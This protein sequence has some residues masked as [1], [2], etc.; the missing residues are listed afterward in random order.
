[1]EAKAEMERAIVDG[2]L[3]KLK[4]L[5]DSG[6]DINERLSYNSFSAVHLAVRHY[7]TDI[8]RFL[9]EEKK[10]NPDSEDEAGFSPLF[11]LCSDTSNDEDEKIVLECFNLL[12]SANADLDIESKNSWTMSAIE[13]AV[14]DCNI[15]MTRALVDAGV[16]LRP[17]TVKVD[18]K[19]GNLIHLAVYKSSES[20]G[21]KQNISFEIVKLLVERMGKDSINEKVN[22]RNTALDIAD[23]KYNN[24]FFN[25]E[26]TS[27]SRFFKNVIDYLEKMGGTRSQYSLPPLEKQVKVD[28]D[29]SLRDIEFLENFVSVMAIAAHVLGTLIEDRKSGH[30]IHDEDIRMAAYACMKID[31]L[32][33]YSDKNLSDQK[34]SWERFNAIQAKISIKNLLD[35][36]SGVHPGDEKSLTDIRC[37]V[38]NFLSRLNVYSPDQQE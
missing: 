17:K 24:S 2:D 13:K 1:M 34:F 23:K 14:F 31:N 27:D 6:A 15:T 5:I 4:G 20:F 19:P 7:Q 21:S 3:A 29:L 30:G 35:P 25:G 8:L 22:G 11:D 16:N 28:K 12:K 9:L 32:M 26:E 36:K 18:G 10:M 33:T 38:C 37:D